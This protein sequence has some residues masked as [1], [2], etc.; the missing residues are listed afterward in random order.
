MRV[1]VRLCK[2]KVW[3]KSK[4]V[5]YGYTQFHCIYKIYDIYKDVAED[6]ET[7]FDTSNY[8]LECHFIERPL[9]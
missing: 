7:R 5:L 8:E 1:L 2:T 3:W 6:V 4:V 9:L